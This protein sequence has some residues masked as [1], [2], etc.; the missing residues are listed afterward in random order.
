[1]FAQNT[2][3]KSSMVFENLENVQLIQDCENIREKSYLKKVC[4][5]VLGVLLN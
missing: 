3:K 5:L 4:I 1:M 2:H